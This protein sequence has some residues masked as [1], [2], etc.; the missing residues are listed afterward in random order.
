M[1]TTNIKLAAALQKYAL[2]ENQPMRVLC[3]LFS[4]EKAKKKLEMYV[5]AD[6]LLALD[7]RA[8]KGATPWLKL[9]IFGDKP[10]SKKCLRYDANVLKLTGAELDYDGGQMSFQEARDNLADAGISAILYTSPSHKPEHP[11]WR[12]LLPFQTPVEGSTLEMKT[13][14][15]KAVVYAEKALGIK[16]DRISYNLSQSYYFGPTEKGKEHYLVEEVNGVCVDNLLDRDG[17]PRPN[18]PEAE[19]TAPAANDLATGL[20]AGLATQDTPGDVERWFREIGSGDSIHPNL[21]SLSGHFAHAGVPEATCR[22]TLTNAVEHSQTDPQ[23]KAA[24]LAEISGIVESAYSKFAPDPSQ[25]SGLR[26]LKASEIPLAAPDWIVQGYFE[27]QTINW[28]YGESEALKTFIMLDLALA[29]C[30]GRE[31][32]P[33]CKTDQALVLYICGEG[34]NGIRRRLAAW[35]KHTNRGIPDNLYI[36]SCSTDFSNDNALGVL[37]EQ[38][39]KLPE[40]PGIVMVDTF[41]RNM[42]GKENEATDI[43][44]FYSN[45]EH[46]L[47]HSYECAV[48]VT[49]HLGKNPAAGLRGSSSIRNNSDSVFKA[50]IGK[51]NDGTVF[52]TLTN[53]KMKDGPKPPPVDFRA[54]EYKLGI[55]DK[56]GNE[57]TSLV[58]VYDPHVKARGDKEEAAGKAKKEID[59]LQEIYSDGSLCQAD[60][61][62]R[63]EVAQSSVSRWIKSLRKQRFISGTNGK[64]KVIQAGLDKLGVTDAPLPESVEE[65]PEAVDPSLFMEND[66]ESSKK[67]D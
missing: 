38:I 9:A 41:A 62:A 27:A 34:K 49:H 31:W 44:T 30:E 25:G 48:I 35:S 39:D 63:V 6:G 15:K 12:V 50:K 54:V 19:L 46:L 45:V 22:A 14:R 66:L 67:G 58:L 4:D 1:N 23:R 32:F 59:L 29:I 8:D 10:S 26:L 24:R 36:S 11:K 3:T 64:L 7:P 55:K 52:T 5:T 57:S 20:A 43:G 51:T 40:T 28:I 37:V 33:G 2:P 16:A 56:Y 18:S 21:L 61:A 53:E 60:Y 17:I 13:Y 47:V 65:I 42:G